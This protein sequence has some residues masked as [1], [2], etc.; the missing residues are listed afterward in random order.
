MPSLVSRNKFLIWLALGGILAL[1][2]YLR[3]TAVTESLVWSPYRADAAQYYNY[4]YN[5][6]RYG[7]YSHAQDFDNKHPEKLKPDAF[8]TPGYPLFL[9]IF[10]TQPPNNATLRTIELWQAVLGTLTVLIIFMIFRIIVPPWVAICATLLTAVSPHLVNTTIYVLS[11]TLFTFVVALVV[12][13]LTLQFGKRKWFVLSMLV[14]GILIGLAALTRPVLEYFLPCV[15]FLLF[16]SYVRNRAF[17]GSVVLVLGFLLIWGPW[18]ARN[19][20]SVKTSDNQLM[21]GTLHQGMYPGLMYKN[22]PQTLAYP[23]SFDP[24]YKEDNKDM[25]SVMRA[26]YRQFKQ[27]PTEETAWYLFGKPVML[28]SWSSIAGAGDVFIYPTPISPYSNSQ[29]FRITHAFMYG[30]RWPL[31]IAALLACVLVW[32]P[33]TKRLFDNNQ[34]F[35]LRAMSLLLFYNTGILMIGAPFP[36][37]SIPFLPILF[38]MAI[39]FA[40]VAYRYLNKLRQQS[41]A[42][43]T[44]KQTLK[45]R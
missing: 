19:Y 37:Y 29:V 4:A 45:V 41:R 31:V 7:I 8:R 34:L 44:A 42:A 3:Y 12:M 13:A 33:I 15:M 6:R 2:A 20:I 14:T 36:R 39:V 17:K 43:Y 16:L 18:V 27:N 30:W 40:F 9:S 11:E 22:N 38:G 21:M 23:Y 1:A 35:L 25:P 28:W 24:T 32:L 10:T 5:L 26:I